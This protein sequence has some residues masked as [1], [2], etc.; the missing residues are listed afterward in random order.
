MART[1]QTPVAVKGKDPRRAPTDKEQAA[2]DVANVALEGNVMDPPPIAA[3]ATGGSIKF[4]SPHN[5]DT[6]WWA[7]LSHSMGL[8]G[9]VMTNVF[10]AV[11]M[12]VRGASAPK[13]QEEADTI[14]LEVREGVAFIQALNP[15][16][17]TE[18]TLGL[19]M[20]M[21]HCATAKL[22]RLMHR[23]DLLPQLTTYGHLLNKSARTF[24]AQVETLQK[25]RTGGKQQVE[26]RYVYVDART[27]T[28]INEGGGGCLEKL[29]QPRAPGRAIGH[30]IAAGL[31][32]RGQDPEGDA[33]PVSG[34]E[35]AAALPDARGLESRCAGG[36]G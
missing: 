15:T 34:G 30:E 16:N 22:S 25:L 6:G 14:A 13:T 5:D 7:S 24:T 23:A 2:I 33:L 8:K 32:L 10:T 27:Q 4:A 35:R 31:P 28:V 36:T 19:H 1:K 29:P 12:N 3:L 21:T 11:L 18:A 20:W 9:A 17:A 26:V